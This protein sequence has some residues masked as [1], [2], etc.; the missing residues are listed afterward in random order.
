MRTILTD[1]DSAFFP[2]FKS[3]YES[4]DD[5]LFKP[6]HSIC[7]LHKIQNFI[8]KLN[9]IKLSKNERLRAIKLFDIVCYS[10]NQNLADESLEILSNMDPI[11]NKYIKKHIRSRL[12]QFSRSYLSERYCLGYNTT[13]LGESINS[14]IKRGL[15][16][17]VLTLL[18]ARQ[19][20]NQT[21]DI[22]QRN[23]L[24]KFSQK[25]YCLNDIEIKYKIK[26]SYKIRKMI[27]LEMEKSMDYQIEYDDNTNSYKA[28]NIFSIRSIYQITKL[29]CSCGF[30]TYTG[31]PCCHLI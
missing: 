7:A 4:W 3:L 19:L 18:E 20:I 8:K 5:K 12:F 24:Y 29:K 13:S 25:R 26:F 17:R 28:I 1:E 2:A 11:L 22:H 21:L 9:K 6:F 16:N 15:P 30:V 27:N 14:L 31:I 10:D 23:S